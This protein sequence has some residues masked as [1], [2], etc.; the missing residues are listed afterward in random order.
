M[1]YLI[2]PSSSKGL[3]EL[4]HNKG[5]WRRQGPNFILGQV[6]ALRA[7]SHKPWLQVGRVLCNCPGQ[8]GL[9]CSHLLQIPGMQEMLPAHKIELADKELQLLYVPRKPRQQLAIQPGF[10]NL[11]VCNQCSQGNE[12]NGE[13]DCASLASITNS[14][15]QALT[16]KLVFSMMTLNQKTQLLA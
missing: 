13:S 6:S 5:G 9:Q 4:L 7:A 2:C 15:S 3:P 1:G 11:L 14:T 10:S 12:L 16:R 8:L